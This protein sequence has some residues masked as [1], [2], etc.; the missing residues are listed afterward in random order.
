MINSK[1]L[2]GLALANLLVAGSANS[3][4]DNSKLINTSTVAVVLTSTG[5]SVSASPQVSQ[6]TLLADAGEERSAA[7]LASPGMLNQ[8]QQ[9]KLK[10]LG[11][12]VVIPTYLPKGFQIADLIANLCTAEMPQT[13]ECREGSSYSIIYRN[14]NNTCLAVNAIGG[15]IGGGADEFQYET[16][17]DLLGTVT[18]AFGRPDGGPNLPNPNQLQHPQTNLSSL[19]ALIQSKAKS[20]YYSVAVV[21]SDSAYGCRQ[22]QSVSPQELEKIV[23]SL[24]LN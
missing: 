17:T 5:F 19:P 23:R 22:N 8:S 2:T 4:I 21:E 15:G 14:N 3:A 16:K 6:S 9:D 18:I 1:L 12:P 13:G 11:V 20:L 10:Q 7:A 24:R